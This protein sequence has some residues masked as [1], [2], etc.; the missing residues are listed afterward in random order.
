MKPLNK[1]LLL[2][3]I[4][5]PLSGQANENK[6]DKIALNKQIPVAE[7]S[8][9]VKPKISIVIDDLGDNSIIAKAMLSLPAK[10]TAAI[11]PMTPHAQLISEFASNKGH[12][13]IMHLPMEASSRY[14]LL[15]PEALMA[16]MDKETFVRIFDENANSIPR[17][18]GFNNHMGSRLTENSE[19]MLWLM[20]QAKKRSY[21]FLDSKTSESSIAEDVAKKL[22]VPSIGR[23]IF[24][25]HKGHNNSLLEQFTKLKQIARR[26]GQVVVICH[27]YPETLKFLKNNISSLDSEFD[28]VSVSELF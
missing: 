23:D 5:I 25:D 3:S 1:L 9:L 7:I 15:G 27:P 17:M 28:L 22:G 18:I 16:S 21:F 24:L 13:I 20:S 10:M 11:L 8:K 19:K 26:N 14:D 2:V 4:F 12:E 6:F